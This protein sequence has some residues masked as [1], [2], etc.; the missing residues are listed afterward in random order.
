MEA[1]KAVQ[2]TISLSSKAT[3]M[4]VSPKAIFASL[5][6][7]LSVETAMPTTSES[8][9]PIEN[10]LEDLA[11][12]LTALQ[13]IPEEEQTTE[14]QEIQYAILQLQ[15]LQ[16]ESKQTQ[17]MAT[18]QIDV[19]A[20]ND[21]SKL[22][23]LL[24]KIQEK[25]QVLLG[26]PSDET[27]HAQIPKDSAQIS[28]QLTE[29][30]AVLDKQQ[31]ETK[32]NL[33][34]KTF[35]QHS[36][37][38]SLS[39][40]NRSIK[41]IPKLVT[42]LLKPIKEISKVAVESQKASIAVETLELK[43]SVKLQGGEEIPP[44]KAPVEVKVVQ[45]SPAQPVTFVADAGKTLGTAV[46]AEALPVVRLPNLLEDLSGMLKSSMRLAESP[47]GMKMRVNIFPEHLGHL[48]ILMTSTNGKLAAQIMA[49]TPMAKEALELQLNQLRNSLI[50]Q[51]VEVEKIEVI[52]QSAQQPFSQQ[53]SHAEQRFT[54]Q[55]QNKG[56]RNTNSY[57]QSED[58]VV[59]KTRNPMSE[60]LM[61]VDYT[62]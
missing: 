55:Q 7:S 9:T 22:V 51:G 11:S 18:S 37:T 62:V 43:P 31:S 14:Q 34:L 45:E 1:L 61:K 25:L 26:Q 15:E 50:Q 12:L 23:G 29:L 21:Q 52:D 42:E 17:S 16:T 19:E 41:E 4:S 40:E 60:G 48:E 13:E 33:L 24:E 27:V 3:A 36:P 30:I 54:Q 2:P 46:K 20:P 44:A 32:V 39:E 53:Q 6:E 47:E 28:K 59:T 35:E 10:V 58:E 8:S 49:S 56:P 38:L 5:L 57:F